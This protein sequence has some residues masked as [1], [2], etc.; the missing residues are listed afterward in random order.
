M[1][2]RQQIIQDHIEKIAQLLN[3]NEDRAFLRFGQSLI[4]GQSIHAFDPSDFVEGG[5]DKQIDVVTIEEG[6]DRAD[7]YIL[8]FKN[9]NTFSSNALIQFHNGLKW[10]FNKRRKDLLALSNIRLKDK[11]T[12][13][14]SLQ[15]GFGPSNIRIIAGFIT[16]GFTSELSEEFQ[17]EVRSI[18]DDYD[19]DTF[20]EFRLFI[21]GADEL[22]SVLNAQER[23]SRKINAEIKIRYDTN[24]P[25]LIKYY[26]ED[27]KGL[28]CSIPASE[29]AR[30]VND[31]PDESIFDLNIRRF[32]GT[33][34]AVNKDI[35]STCT[36]TDFSHQFWFLNNGITVVCDR[37]DA[38]TDPDN[39]K[40]IVENLK[41]VNGCQTAT[42]IALAQREGNL[43]ADIR[44]LMRIYESTDPD[45]VN[46][47]VL[48]TNN[49]NKISSRD[50]RANDPIQIDMEKAFEIHNYYYERKVR[51]FDD[52]QLDPVR[53]IPNELVAQAYLAIALKTPSDGRARKYKVWSEQYSRIFSGG[54]VEPYIICV[55]ILRNSIQWL[56]ESG[57]LEHSDEVNRKIA[58]LG[59][60]HVARI[61]AYLWR[62][63]DEWR[64][65]VEDLRQNLETLEQNSTVLAHHLEQSFTQLQRLIRD[66]ESFSGDIE[67]ALKSYEL[68]QQITRDLH[69][70][71]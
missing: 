43:P 15:S 39:P 16:N 27:L 44:V 38:V 28:V 26:S 64:L 54:N 69:T 49:Q 37:F 45:L 21:Y 4:V 59:T 36:S 31:D 56:G 18:R 71:S 9:T 60:F 17:Q 66:N 25:S 50:L 68:D 11:I 8:S 46:R 51:Q 13:Y 35:L 57:L 10:I 2:I 29:I 53:I 63:S 58:K 34:G 19:N 65:P 42:T 1:E 7:V 61:A 48:T 33:R 6:P 32:L 30:L 5:Q 23:R 40:I 47:I 24:N 70:A 62:G 3:I 20:E 14:R 55:L 52:A 12:E 41:I 22:V 67:R